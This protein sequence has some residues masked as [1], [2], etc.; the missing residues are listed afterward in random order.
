VPRQLAGF[1]ERHPAIEIALAVHGRVELLERIGRNE[2]DLYIVANPPG[3]GIVTQKIMPNPSVVV[4]RADHPLA[5]V[6]GIA[7][8]RMAAEPFIARERA[9]GTRR[10]A[11]EAFASR[12][13][14]PRI[15]MEASSNE[16][17]KQAILAGAGISILSRC[18]LES[19]LQAGRLTVL[20]VEGFPL[21]GHWHFAY[22]VGKQVPATAR[23]F[24]DFVRAEALASPE[25]APADPVL[26]SECGAAY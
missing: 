16:A 14:K 22:P 24:M 12:G 21:P 15:R 18:T 10:I 17:V 23:A 8:E 26:P 2:D 6:P 4:A 1:S 7:F 3:E 20:D 25:G 11:E 5:D 19:D 13:L 9:S